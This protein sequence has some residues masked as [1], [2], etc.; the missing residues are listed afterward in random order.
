MFRFIFFGLAYGASFLLSACGGGGGSVPVSDVRDLTGS[1]APLETAADQSA[2][3]AAI[4]SRSDSLISSTIFV[5]TNNSDYPTFRVRANC[6]RTAC[7]FF[8]PQT[9]YRETLT[10]RDLE[11]VPVRE[12][13]ALS[14][15]GITLRGGVEEGFKAYG[16]WM[17]HSAFQVSAISESIDGV[18]LWGQ[19]GLAG[20]DLSGT[21][22]D[23]S[24]TWRGVMVGTPATG[25][26]RGD[27]LQGDALLIYGFDAS[28]FAEVDASFDNIK[29]IDKNR[30]HSVASVRFDDVPVY[31]DGTFEAGVTGNKI[32]GGFYGPGHAEATGAFEQSNIVGSFGARR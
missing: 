16:S 31:T 2:R 6:I 24:A 3:A 9:G 23:T 18:S 1:S 26:S 19:Q 7:T 25:A 27:F 28:G 13:I 15:Y 17:R 4:I 12:T 5:E 22:P 10:V 21:A 11:F 30:S 20:G 14:K 8:E 32:Q 29:N